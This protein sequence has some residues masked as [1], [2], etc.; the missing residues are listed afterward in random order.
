MSLSILSKLRNVTAKENNVD[1]ALMMNNNIC[2]FMYNQSDNW[3]TLTHN[4]KPFTD[5]CIQKDYL[6]IK[7]P[8]QN[9]W[10]PLLYFFYTSRILEVNEQKKTIEVDVKLKLAWED[11]RIKASFHGGEILLPYIT[12]YR[13]PMIW[14]PFQSYH[15]YRVKDKKY[16][17]DPI[18]IGPIRLHPSNHYPND[19]I[20]TNGT[21]VEAWIEWHITVSCEFDFVLF[22]FDENECRL[23][24]VFDNVNATNYDFSF[25]TV[26]TSSYEWQGF[27]FFKKPLKERVGNCIA[28]HDMPCSTFG[29]EIKMQRIVR[30]FVYQYFLPCIS[31][32]MVSF[33]SFVVPL[34]AIPG[35]VALV[36]TQCLTLTNIFIYQRVRNETSLNKTTFQT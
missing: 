36:V 33:L 25:S 5:V 31:I 16:L 1:A 34:S 24:M 28:D 11:W 4:R 22:P 6:A 23:E 35:R 20:T 17:Q 10:V 3:E 14:T 15:I 7:P 29:L 9:G 32:V 30:P 27:T 13:D 2:N 26:P 12:R 21:I 8:I 18:R 19:L